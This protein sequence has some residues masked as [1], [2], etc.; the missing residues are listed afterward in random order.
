MACHFAPRCRA[1]FR[2]DEALDTDELAIMGAP[3]L[4]PNKAKL[5]ELLASQR[6]TAMDA[7]GDGFVAKKE[8][9]N[10]NREQSGGKSW[11]GATQASSLEYVERQS[12]RLADKNAD[13]QLSPEETQ[14]LVA[15]AQLS[16]F[17][18]A[19]SSTATLFVYADANKD[20]SLSMKELQY[21][22]R[23]SHLLSMIA[24]H[25]EMGEGPA[26]FN[27]AHEEL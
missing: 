18:R 11:G 14:T 12:F 5:L 19:K 4:S 22:K 16:V 26:E 10:W 23:S 13:L 17:Q 1:L 20:E 15:D 6:H 2:Q 8:Y 9:H 24:G 21:M 7:D 3:S 27:A 25:A